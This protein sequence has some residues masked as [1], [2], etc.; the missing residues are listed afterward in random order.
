MN[1][2]MRTIYIILLDYF[3][4]LASLFIGSLILPGLTITPQ[5]HSITRFLI[6]S[7]L[8]LVLYP[9][10]LHFFGIYRIIHRYAQSSEYLRFFFAFLVAGVIFSILN[11][12]LGLFFPFLSYTPGFLLFFTILSSSGMLLSRLV[13]RTYVNRVAPE[14]GEQ[15]VNA[16]IVGCG[17]ACLL[18][19]DELKY[20]PEHLIKPVAAVD[21]DP[22]KTGRSIAGIPILGDDTAIPAICKQYDIH[23]IIVAIPSADNKQRARILENCKGIDAEVKLLPR[24]AD[25]GSAE[26]G[27]VEKLRD[28]TMEELLGRDP[29]EVN[30][31]KIDAFIRGKTVLVTGG[32]GSI[33]SEL[34]RQIASNAP[35]QLVIV[36][37]YENNAYDIQQE[38]VFRYGSALNLKVL[39]ASVRDYERIDRIFAT[40]KPDIVIH[41]AAHKH[42]P[43]MEVSPQEAIKNNVFGTYNTARAAIH[44]DVKKFI[45]ISTDKAVN[46]TNIMGA[47][48]RMCEMVIQSLIGHGT[49]F[50]A[51][52]FG[53]VLGSNGSVIP[54]FKK[55]IAKGGPVTV[56]HP[57]IIRF[58]MTIPEAVQLVLMASAKAEGGEIFVLNMGSP[59]KIDDLARKIIQ[60]SGKKPDVDIMV[61]YTGLRPGEKLYEELMMDDENLEKT[62]NDKILVGH[63]IDF[64]K[65]RLHDELD[66]LYRIAN[67]NT[68]SE[69]EMLEQLEE[70]ISQVV[71]T[72]H[73]PKK[74]SHSY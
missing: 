58:F 63:F 23:M 69:G 20:H 74:D 11:L 59:V 55:Q 36:D 35:K 40:Y 12:L 21:N 34:C 44:N 15:P 66:E 38:L 27:V 13:Y 67:D 64:D 72:F 43:L 29:I 8:L 48:K 25:F 4:L 37:I 41:A 28:F 57:D 9:L 16:L 24:L 45:L 33:G 71:P 26:T 10:I 22:V 68:L 39:I 61:E 60:L 53:N 50:S 5:A 62:Q 19:L 3:T 1:A 65:E 30:H 54:L 32:G 70:K 2:K 47:C 49:I 51:V 14:K 42:V 56:T 7:A 17:Q 31:E 46:P 73:R 6:A 52:R 18:L